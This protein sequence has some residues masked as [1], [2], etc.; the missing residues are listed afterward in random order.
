MDF[1][2][3]HDILNL[4]AFESI[5][6]EIK[7]TDPEMGESIEL[8]LRA[9]VEETHLLIREASTKERLSLA[10]LK[11]KIVIQAQSSSYLNITDEVT[12]KKANL[13]EFMPQI[14]NE[15]MDEVEYEIRRYFEKKKSE[16]YKKVEKDSTWY[17]GLRDSTKKSGG[18]LYNAT[19]KTINKGFKKM[20]REEA[21]SEK[22]LAD[23]RTIVE[24]LLEEHLNQK[25]VAQ[26]VSNILER[27]AANYKNKWLEKISGNMPDIK[28]LSAFSVVDSMKDSLKVNFQLGTA[29]QVLAM[30]LGSAVVGVLGLSIG[31]H[32][33]TYA[34]LNVFPPIAIF[35][36][37]ATVLVGVLTKDK[38][39][40]K[41]KKDIREAVSQYYF[42]FLQQLYV[43]KLPDLGGQSISKYMENQGIVI[44]EKAV[45]G[46]EREL[47][48][49]L[50]I[51]HYR[52]LNQA[53]LR[54][55]MYL[56]EALEEIEG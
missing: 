38:A 53:F 46:W 51:E 23:T 32:T 20:K 42:Y 31:W 44:V 54:H 10:L 22:Y 18:V 33:L 2:Y 30:G 9:A 36:G 4:M 40:D 7:S 37:V 55:L 26:Y 27:A 15:F 6:S 45:Q 14:Y 25:D 50:K 35:A 3:K 47:F 12:A 24:E 41:R 52:R 49:N 39:I 1:L 13:L 43:L 17:S 19:V 8:A 5:F 28:R 21:I 16:M 56:N 48:G 34:L 29:E 11:E